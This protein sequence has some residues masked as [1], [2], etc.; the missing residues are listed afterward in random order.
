MATGYEQFD[1]SVYGEYGY[2][3]YKDVISGLHFERLVNASGPTQGHIVRPSDHKEPK[4]VVIWNH[5]ISQ[6]NQI[7][8][9]FHL[10]TQ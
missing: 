1:H 8:S 4:T 6:N 5:C 3:K 10:L 9:Y 2:G 7:G